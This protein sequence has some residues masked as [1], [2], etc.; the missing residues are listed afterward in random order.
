MQANNGRDRIRRRWRRGNDT[1]F[2]ETF[3]E[4]TMTDLKKVGI[5]WCAF[6]KNI[7]MVYR[8]WRNLYHQ[9]WIKVSCIFAQGPWF[10]HVAI[11]KQD[12]LFI[13]AIILSGS[14]WTYIFYDSQVMSQFKSI[15]RVQKSDLANCELKIALNDFYSM[16]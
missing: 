14:I 5:I 8:Y 10:W 4:W 1:L 16:L 9:L 3:L 15:S 7:F 11:D 13:D 6:W 2:D 12:A